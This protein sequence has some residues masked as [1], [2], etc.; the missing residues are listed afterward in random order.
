MHCRVFPWIEIN[1]NTKVATAGLV[2]AS[3]LMRV[4]EYEIEVAGSSHH[5]GSNAP[6]IY[7]D[8]WMWMRIAGRL[9]WGRGGPRTPSSWQ[10]P[11]ASSSPPLP[12]LPHSNPFL[13][14]EQ[15]Q[16]CTIIEI[17]IAIILTERYDREVQRACSRK[18]HILDKERCAVV[19]VLSFY[20]N[21]TVVKTL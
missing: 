5:G 12:C 13:P 19:S 14:T 2:S 4:Y 20:K 1:K 16:G 15:L 3:Q 21:A 9:T 7:Y 8:I 11:A 18:H 10:P 6:S 17:I